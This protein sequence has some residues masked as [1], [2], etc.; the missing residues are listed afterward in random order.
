MPQRYHAANKTLHLMP[1]GSQWSQPNFNNRS[2]TRDFG[3][4]KRRPRFVD[5]KKLDQVA[6]GICFA[7]VAWGSMKKEQ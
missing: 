5:Y 4:T 6:H 2:S 1:L 7:E 3:G